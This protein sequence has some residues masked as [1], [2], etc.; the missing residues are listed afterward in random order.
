[1][2]KR[3]LDKK[4]T[5]NKKTVSDLNT[6]DMVVVKAGC[7]DTYPSCVPTYTRCQTECP[8]GFMCNYC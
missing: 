7:V 6:G 8:S 2:K 3:V 5:L 4:L 1:M